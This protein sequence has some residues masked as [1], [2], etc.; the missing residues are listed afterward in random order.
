MHLVAWCHAL[1]LSL[2]S[3]C[4][5]CRVGME[6]C[7]CCGGGFLSCMLG[8]GAV[9]SGEPPRTKPPTFYTYSAPQDADVSC[10]RASAAGR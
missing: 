8:A 7:W 3:L 4:R 6:F 5:I 2:W 9:T 10:G 1:Q